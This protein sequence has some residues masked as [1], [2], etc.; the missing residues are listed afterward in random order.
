[1]KKNLIHSLMLLFAAVIIGSTP[2]QAGNSNTTAPAEE[3]KVGD[4]FYKDGSWSSTYKATAGNPC[5]GLVFATGS[6][7]GDKASNYPGKG[8]EKIRGYVMALKDTNA[9]VSRFS[10][11]AS[12]QSDGV[13]TNG[14]RCSGYTDTQA[15][16]RSADYSAANYP[17]VAACLA[18]NEAVPTPAGTSGWYLP[19][20]AQLTAIA[21]A[22]YNF[23]E[24]TEG[25]LY[26]QLEQLRKEGVAAPMGRNNYWTST[27]TK[28]GDGP[29]RTSFSTKPDNKT[30]GEMRGTGLDKTALSRAV[31]TF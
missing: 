30:Y 22:Y 20:G 31:F 7:V 11:L 15:I 17:A 29:T 9:G 1:M 14:K 16:S 24:A 26:Q 10:T 5:I 4:F 13:S 6:G 19:S 25:I 12:L 18:Y 2:V 27:A 28:T 21:L 8:M 3:P 23:A